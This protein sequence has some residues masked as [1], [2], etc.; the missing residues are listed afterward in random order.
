MQSG[1][2]QNSINKENKTSGEQKS[3]YSLLKCFTGGFF[4]PVKFK[5]E[6]L[7][8]IIIIFNMCCLF[9]EVMC[10]TPT[11]NDNVYHYG[12]LLR[13]N[14][15]MEAGENFWDCWVPYWTM[16]YPVF[17]YYQPLPY[18]IVIIIYNLLGKAFDLFTVFRVFEYLLVTTFPLTVYL[19]MKKIEFSGLEATFCAVSASLISTNRLYGWEWESHVWLGYGM[20]AQLIS[21]YIF[22][23]T[24][25]VIYETLE[26][27]RGYIKAVF[28]LS[29]NFLLHFFFGYLIILF[30]FFLIFIFPE[31]KIILKKL[32]KFFITGFFTFLVLMHILIPF[33]LHKNYHAHSVF[34]SLWKTDSYGIEWIIKK[35]LNGDLLD[36]DRFCVLTILAVAGLLI[37]I[38]RNYNHYRVVWT[39]F[40]FAL[41]L[42]SGRTTWG[43][44]T[45]II[46]PMGGSLHLHRFINAFDLGVVM[47]SGVALAYLW[48]K[49]NYRRSRKSLI[50]ALILTVLL[51]SPAFYDRLSFSMAQAK[52]L[53]KA[54]AELAGE[55]PDFSVVFAEIKNKDKVRVYPGRKGDWGH[56]FRVGKVPCY[57][58]LAVNKLNC[59][60]NL[61]FSWSLNA[62]FQCFFNRSRF[63][64]CRLYNTGYILSTKKE[65]FPDFAVKIK[66]KGDYLLY[67]VNDVSYFD[68][69]DV[70]VLLKGDNKNFWNVNLLWLKSSF[71]DKKQ[72]M[73]I[74][75]EDKLSSEDF[76]R[77]FL[78]KDRVTFLEDGTE[79]NVFASDLF[80]RPYPEKKDGGEILSVST[81]GFYYET[82]VFVKRPCYLLFKM[83]FHPN[84]IVTVD[85][86]ESDK[87]H[88]SP[89]FTGVQLEE[90][91]HTVKFRYN[92]GNL[93][94]ILLIAGLIS[95]FFIFLWEGKEKIFKRRKDKLTDL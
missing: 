45:D 19:G 6:I 60:S 57:S 91:K 87:I 34:D 63:S 72:H 73:A 50:T 9:P 90:G 47:C 28:L 80:S 67:K 37:S 75:F 22:P 84:W 13:M 27:N 81:N 30:S 54:S 36:A 77:T 44:I 31:K 17:H 38:S 64:H 11:M 51:L 61:P 39:I 86:K 35:F 42:Y 46:L 66:E 12:L 65:K 20:Y 88:L 48:E 82:E 18:L 16:G 8:L 56:D 94:N 29:L 69:V 23:L 7:L 53:K 74:D 70:P 92:P 71:V 55:Y 59:L 26:K 14:D 79:K 93:K 40:F 15:A 43:W 52:Y 95:L 4:S 25:G 32:K 2:M 62:D 5:P 58:F 21:L 3:R 76:Q 83:T 10:I 49:L 24:L 1:E 89:S 78:M 68:L 33:Y 85:G 41:I